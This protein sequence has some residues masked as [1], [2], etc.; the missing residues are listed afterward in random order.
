MIEQEGVIKY[1]LEHREC[2]LAA[3]VDISQINAWRGLLFRLQLIG[4]SAEKYGGLGY[5][6]ISR[7]LAPDSP[8]F[9]ISGTQT[10][11]L[12]SLRAKH[13]A[14]VE[15]A[16]PLNNVIHS[17]GPSKPS[18]EAL[19]H[20]SVYLH[21]PNVQAVIH[22]H[23]PEIW[24]QTKTL[25]LPCTE[26]EIAY[27]SVAMAEAVEQLFISGQLNQRPIF[28]MLGHQDGIV[29]FGESLTAAALALITLLAQALA[30]EQSGIAR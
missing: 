28:S 9:L 26:A 2:A 7:L 24:R 18:S 27:G 15:T 11:H 21:A 10:G 16:S 22:V 8:R 12:D 4:Q 6:N 30:I 14:I 17:S 3:S 19:T 25:G 13:F 1:R 29:A 20:A 23:C 5:G